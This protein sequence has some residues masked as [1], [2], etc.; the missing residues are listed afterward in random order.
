MC[1]RSKRGSGSD[2]VEDKTGGTILPKRIRR[3][4]NGRQ[5]GGRLSL[6]QGLEG[7]HDSR[8]ATALSIQRSDPN[9]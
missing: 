5:R 8:C 2:R 4:G 1:E 6:G 7:R 3:S 9:L